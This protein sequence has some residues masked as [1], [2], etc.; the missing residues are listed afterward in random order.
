M[1]D[2]LNKISTIRPKDTR[3]E[4]EK[5]KKLIVQ[6]SRDPRVTVLKIADRLEV[7]RNLEIFPKQSRENKILETLMLYIPLAHQLGLYNIKSEM[8]DIYFRFSEPEQY[9]AIT[10]KLTATEKDRERLTLEFVEPLKQALS[11]DGIRYILKA[12]TKTAYSIWR[13]M[14]HQ[15]VPFEGVH[16]VFA[17][18]FIIDCEPDPKIEKDLCWKVY[19]RVTEEYEPDTSRLRDWVT[20]PKPN[21]Y[22][23]L[24]ITVKNKLGASVE[25]QIRTTRMNQE[26]EKGQA[27]HWAY[28]GIRHEESLDKWLA[29]VRYNLEHVHEVSR[30]NFRNPFQGD[31]R[32]HPDRELRILPV[33]ATVLISPSTSIPDWE[34]AHRGTGQRKGG[35]DPGETQDRGCG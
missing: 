12:R 32:V 17:I 10:N 15:K 31:L 1:V 27:S 14:Q 34:H 5:Y 7:M 13:K 28:K 4:A 35:L 18:R 21:G 26:A 22:E 6:Y 8:E 20:T 11:E 16:D 30:K 33:G 3:L 29:S 9:R 23:S 25:V 2:G 19:S 24:H